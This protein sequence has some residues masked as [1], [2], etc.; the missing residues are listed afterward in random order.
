MNERDDLLLAAQV[1]AGRP[2][3]HGDDVLVPVGGRLRRGTVDALP[4]DPVANG[5]GWIVVALPGY[6]G[7]LSVR[8]RNVERVNG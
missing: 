8:A 7:G 1:A 4:G 3:Q 2:L 5:C 6:E